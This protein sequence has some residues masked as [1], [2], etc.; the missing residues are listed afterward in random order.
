MNRSLPTSGDTA[1]SA[2]L[3]I[4]YFV[5]LVPGLFF[6][7]PWKPDE[8]YTF[9]LVHHMMESGDWVVPMLGGE[10]FVEK[11]PIFFVVAAWFA[12][13][14]SPWLPAHDGARLA[15]AL[16]MSITCVFTALAARALHGG[17][18]GVLAVLIL[19]GSIG[20]VAHGHQLITDMALM[21]GF[22]IALYGYVVSVNRPWLGGLLLGT[23]VGLG[24][25]AKGLIA[26]G[27][28]G[29]IAVILPCIDSTWRRRN[30]FLC[31][32]LSLFVMLPWLSLW[33]WL[34]YRESPELFREWLFVQ[35][36]GRFHGSAHLGYG[37]EPAFYLKI[38][39]W[40][41]WPAWPMAV[42]SL[43]K[44]GRDGLRQPSMQLPLVAFVVM[45]LILTL[46]RE[47]RELYALPLLLPLAFLATAGADSLRLPTA[48]LLDRSGVAAIFA[49]AFLLWAGWLCMIVNWPLAWSQWIRHLFGVTTA[50]PFKP[51]E[52][53]LA[54]IATVACVLTMMA[55]R[56]DGRR[57]IIDWMAGV[58]LLWAL[59]MSLWLPLIDEHKGYRRTMAAL[60]AALPDHY[61]CLASQ[62]L[63]EPQRALFDYYFGVQTLRLENDEDAECR[64][65]L[66]QGDAKQLH[67]YTAPYTKIWEGG[68]PGDTSERFWLL[69][70][71]E[72]PSDTSTLQHAAFYA[73]RFQRI[74]HK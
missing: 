12:D 22:A 9:G 14:F 7:D 19:L 40:F 26:P 70:R 10:P 8:A 47:A 30:Y 44:R 24:F 64:F 36:W 46:A 56:N 67:V 49:L 50:L 62:G 58:A 45:L 71:P 17:R 23:G 39:F 13:T 34:L 33:P 21:S 28:L 35:N 41:G 42:W 72:A 51:G 43:W 60:Y 73:R 53:I 2:L 37:N 31:L 57:P 5:W 66:V 61:D 32:A 3:L 18:H 20:L 1:L 52:L 59:A 15:T 38:L 74:V 25:M 6:H 54:S 29:L 11:P 48:R 4:A 69:E 55:A 27:M 65:L 16:F 63:G 68:R